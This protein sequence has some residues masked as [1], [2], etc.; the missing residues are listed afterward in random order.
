M[1]QEITVFR[2][3]DKVRKPVQSTSVNKLSSPDVLPSAASVAAATTHHT[4]ALAAGDGNH[5][6]AEP[7]S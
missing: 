6:T 4:D 5:T 3:A 1:H 2:K 7:V